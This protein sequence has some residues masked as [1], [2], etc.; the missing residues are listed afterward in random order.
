MVHLPLSQDFRSRTGTSFQQLDIGLADD[1]IAV[2]VTQKLSK[3]GINSILLQKC[4]DLPKENEELTVLYH[5]GQRE[6]AA[7][8]RPVAL[9]YEET[10]LVVRGERSL[11][12][13][14][15]PWSLP[16]T[17]GPM[18]SCS[19]RYVAQLRDSSVI[20]ESYSQENETPLTLNVNP[21]RGVAY[22]HCLEGR[23]LLGAS[24]N[25]DEVHMYCLQETSYQQCGH[26]STNKFDLKQVIENIQ[27]DESGRTLLQ[28]YRQQHSDLWQKITALMDGNEE[29]Q[30]WDI[31]ALFQGIAPASMIPGYG[32]RSLQ[33]AAATSLHAKYPRVSFTDSCSPRNEVEPD[34]IWALR[35]SLSYRLAEVAP[36]IIAGGCL[37]SYGELLGNMILEQ[38][39]HLGLEAV[40]VHGDLLEHRT[41]AA[42]LIRTVSPGCA[43]YGSII[44]PQDACGALGE[45]VERSY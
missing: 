13:A 43:V 1:L 28:N 20:I 45:M 11:L 37:E 30:L 16:L 39:M 40:V 14:S 5:N 25:S 12:P 29:W 41:F 17:T 36:E 9:R 24:L 38:V 15:L 4:S 6:A 23:P 22:Q 33:D 18:H 8:T 19:N 3:L 32:L 42:A 44:L 10:T 35:S 26:V 7:Q 21:L 31:V 27:S 34:P 2:L